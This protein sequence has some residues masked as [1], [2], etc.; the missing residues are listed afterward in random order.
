MG[1]QVRGARGEGRTLVGGASEADVPG[2]MTLTFGLICKK[3][4]GGGCEHQLRSEG[5]D[6]CLLAERR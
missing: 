3:G 1:E 4:G 6:A 5:S 2:R